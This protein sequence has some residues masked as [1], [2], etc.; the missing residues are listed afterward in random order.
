MN[1]RWLVS[2]FLVGALAVSIPDYADAQLR[3]VRG[4]KS[5]VG[6]NFTLARPVGEFQNFVDLGG[7]LGVYGV[8]NFDE[9]RHVGLR[10][11]GSW[12]LYGHE[13]FVAPLSNTIRR[14]GVDVDT[15]NFIVHLGTGPQFTFGS[16]PVRPY[17]YGTVGFSYFA[18]VS[19]VSGTA[20]FGDFASSTNFDD[21]TF[22]TTGGGGLLLRLS[23][24]EHPVSL[25]LSAQTT[26]NGEAEYLRRGGIVENRNGSITLLPIRS[27]ANLVSFRI[28]VALGI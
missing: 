2:P 26:Y 4:P 8:V 6:V 3:E 24:G 27:Q 21:L 18:T 12:V 20:S 23:N 16:G 13:S 10:F 15:D 5:I 14:V 11:D 28:G 19:S 1:V 9:G 25:D 7:G 17:V 22:A